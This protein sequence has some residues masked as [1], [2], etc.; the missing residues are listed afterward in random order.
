LNPGSVGQP[1]DRDS[2]AAYSLFITDEDVWEYRRVQYDVEAVQK[3]M[4]DA[5]LPDR[6]IQRLKAGW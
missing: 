5:G 3:R 4:K 1:R 2:R 6:H